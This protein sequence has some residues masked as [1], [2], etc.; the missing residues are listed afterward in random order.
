MMT[1]VIEK[2]KTLLFIDKIIK[3]R[4]NVDNKEIEFLESCAYIGC[5][6]IWDLGC[7]KEI[8]AREA[9]ATLALKAMDKIWK[10]KFI[11]LQSKLRV[12]IGNL[13]VLFSSRK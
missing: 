4:V 11:S 5:R 3:A 9:K 12:L 10:S 1:T 6:F 8:S 7:K 2:S 13:R